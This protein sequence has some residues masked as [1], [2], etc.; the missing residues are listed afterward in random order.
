MELRIRGAEQLASM[1]KA[2]RSAGD[3]KGL[4]KEMY[5]GFQRATKDAKSKPPQV[6]A[7]ELP[8]RGGLAAEVAKAKLSTRTRGGGKSV[9]IQ[10]VAKGKY[11]RQ[12]DRGVIRNSQ[13]V[14]SGWFTETL[15]R[16][17][18]A[19]RKEVIEAMEQ[20]AREIARSA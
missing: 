9:G 6:A 4:R 1:S 8:H 16:A 19:V 13:R 3:G 10:I 18:P 2:L 17:A 5:K 11:L 15:Q 20:V 7:T 14:P 12:T